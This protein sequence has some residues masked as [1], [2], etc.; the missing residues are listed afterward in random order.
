MEGQGL[1]NRLDEESVQSFQ[2]WL[3]T[4]GLELQV[5]QCLQELGVTR[6]AHLD[7]LKEP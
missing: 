1:P 7:E 2:L 3:S 4:N 6:L 5:A